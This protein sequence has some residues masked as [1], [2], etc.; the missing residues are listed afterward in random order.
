MRAALWWTLG[1]VV[2]LA[3]VVVTAFPPFAQVAT[4]GALG[5]PTWHHN[6]ALLVAVLFSAVFWRRMTT[7][8]RFLGLGVMVT[9]I[10]AVASAFLLLYLKQDLKD[11]L[12]KDWAKFWHVAWSWF[13]LVFF[14]G[15]TWVNRHG[16]GRAWKRTT[17]GAGGWL[18]YGLLTLMVVAIPLTWSPWGARVF[19]DPVYIPMTLYTWLVFLVPTYA[20]WLTAAVQMRNNEGMRPT[21]WPRTGTQAFVDAWLIPMTVLANV[22]GF[23]IL[24]FGTKDTALKYV[25]KYWHTWPS[26]AMAILVFAHTVQFF[27][28]VVRYTKPRAVEA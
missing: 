18:F 25:A 16:L 21:W 19:T 10:L 1:L 22:S 15:H 20:V 9:T 14:L 6:V 5:V 4:A 27:P 7:D 8:R 12:L 2:H 26:I 13:G 11:W 23:P 28:A 3:V 17:A 24:Y